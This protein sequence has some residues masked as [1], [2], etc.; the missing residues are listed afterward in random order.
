VTDAWFGEEVARSAGVVRMWGGLLA[1]D[2]VVHGLAPQF[3]GDWAGVEG[4]V[5]MV[6]SAASS[7]AQERRTER[8][9]T[10]VARCRS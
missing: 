4:L 7:C 6:L 8:M 5:E 2:F 1:P 3:S 10:G 9:L